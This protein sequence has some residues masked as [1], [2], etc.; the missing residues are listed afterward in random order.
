ML[1]I[2]LGVVVVFGVAVIALLN[3]NDS[4]VRNS[5]PG[6]ITPSE[7]S[8]AP[9]TPAFRF[10]TS[11]SKLVPTSPGRIRR[12]DR[13][14]SERVATTTRVALRDLYA[15]GF[16]DPTNWEQGVYDDAFRS[17]AGGAREQAVAQLGLL[18]AGARAGDRYDSIEPVSG[19]LGLRIL[20]DRGDKPALVVAS[21]RFAA[22]A[23]G[24]EPATLRSDGLFFFRRI[25]GSWKIVSFHVTRRDAP[26]EAA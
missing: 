10:T 3:R 4:P 14:A 26:R 17:F 2:G 7:A 21:V 9:S 6:E 5:S 20:L 13:R 22:A 15:E 8:A 1:L 11:T 18:T 12:K 23:L 19:R 16:L 25:G 24:L